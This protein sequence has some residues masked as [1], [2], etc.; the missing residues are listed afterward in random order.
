MIEEIRSINTNES[1]VCVCV[2]GI[3]A[4]L[5]MAGLA[6]APAAFNFAEEVADCVKGEGNGDE[7]DGDCEADA[8]HVFTDKRERERRLVATGVARVFFD[9]DGEEGGD[10]GEGEEDDGDYGEDHDCLTLA[11][12]ACGLVAG[13]ACFE[14]VGVLLLEIEEIGNGFVDALGLLVHALNVFDVRIDRLHHVSE[15]PF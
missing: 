2:V 1:V 12:G 14:G 8:K 5:L 4:D 7:G 15:S 3:M 6:F 9:V 11:S 13:E 10:E